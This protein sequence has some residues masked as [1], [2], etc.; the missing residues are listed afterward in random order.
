MKATVLHDQDGQWTFAVVLSTGEEAV[1]RI[2]AFARDEHATS[3][4]RG[5]P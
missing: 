3:T 1:D 4:S 5:A 2:T